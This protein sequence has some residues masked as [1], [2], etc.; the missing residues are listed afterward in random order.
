[1][2]DPPGIAFGAEESRA[3]CDL[4]LR[5]EDVVQEHSEE[6]SSF[7][8]EVL[9][10]LKTPLAS[11]LGVET[12]SNVVEIDEELKE[13]QKEDVKVEEGVEV[14]EEEAQEDE[15][16]SHEIAPVDSLLSDKT[17]EEN[18]DVATLSTNTPSCQD[19]KEEEKVEDT[20]EATEEEEELAVEHFSPLDVCIF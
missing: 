11:S 16:A 19:D 4:V 18:E 10:S 20:E 3:E 6:E 14:K 2:L 1:M 7:L 15:L 17:S 12:E 9:S 13:K 8:Q 5:E